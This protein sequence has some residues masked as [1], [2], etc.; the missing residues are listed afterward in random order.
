MVFGGNIHLNPV[1]R[2]LVAVPEEYPY[3]S[4]GAGIVLDAVPQRLKPA[5]VV[6]V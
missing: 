2:G 1:K 5:S 6:A 3:S 4:A